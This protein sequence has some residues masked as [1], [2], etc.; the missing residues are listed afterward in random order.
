MLDDRPSMSN[1]VESCASINRRANHV[2]MLLIY[3]VKRD[4]FDH[5]PA[6][7]TWMDKL[8]EQDINASRECDNGKRNS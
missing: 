7:F 6:F 4:W 2:T 8:L 3:H 1:H 5:S